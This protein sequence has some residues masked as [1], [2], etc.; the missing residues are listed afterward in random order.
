[1]LKFEAKI[2]IIGV[3]P[4]VLLPKN[5]LKEIFKQAGKEKGTIPVRG[6]LDGH[7][8]VQTLVKYSAKWRLYLNTPMRRSAGKDVGD[9]IEITIEY[10]PAERIIPIHPKLAKALMKNKRA[11]KV[12]KSLSPSM[13]K[14]IVRYFSFLKNEETVDKNI[15]KA[16]DFLLGKGRF[17]GR[18]KP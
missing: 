15:I 13:Q 2:H 10:D 11:S 8:Y 3:N 6:T 1:M 7:P 17:V 14:E 16:I 9:T 12:F 5:I 18:D 4:Y